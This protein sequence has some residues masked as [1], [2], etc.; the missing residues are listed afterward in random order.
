VPD[1]EAAKSMLRSF[2]A[3]VDVGDPRA[4]G[5]KTTPGDQFLELGPRAFGDGFHRAIGTIH[6][7]S[8]Q[9]EFLRLPER[10]SAEIDALDSADNFQTDAGK[11]RRVVHVYSLFRLAHEHPG[12]K[13]KMEVQASQ[14]KI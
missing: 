14:Q 5:A 2:P 4:G 9:S 3:D 7:P 1:R 13:S 8:C 11:F 6:D 10:G 12:R